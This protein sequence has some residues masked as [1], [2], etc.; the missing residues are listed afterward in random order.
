MV[1]IEKV[2]D[3]GFIKMTLSVCNSIL[4]LLLATDEHFRVIGPLVLL[5]KRSSSC[6]IIRFFDNVI[7]CETVA[8][9]TLLVSCTRCA[10]AVTKG[11]RKATG[12]ISRGY[13]ICHQIEYS[14]LL[15]IG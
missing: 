6:Q 2:H 8:T 9:D 14:Q 3:Q 10:N 12:Q 13:V 1:Y 11:R 4:Q 5:R 7:T 15:L